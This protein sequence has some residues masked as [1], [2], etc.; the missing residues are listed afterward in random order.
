MV[1]S[2]EGFCGSFL[3]SC[4][5]CSCASSSMWDLP[6]GNKEDK[7]AGGEGSPEFVSWHR[8]DVCCVL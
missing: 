5:S 7:D 6:A 2:E 4:R 8:E 1:W 3:Q